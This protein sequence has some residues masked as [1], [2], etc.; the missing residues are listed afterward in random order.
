MT[1]M[2]VIEIDNLVV[3]FPSSQGMLRAVDGVSLKVDEGEV[4]GIQLDLDRREVGIAPSIERRRLGQRD[5]A[6]DQPPDDEDGAHPRPRQDFAFDD[7][8][9]QR[10]GELQ[11][12]Q[13]LALGPRFELGEIDAPAGVGAAD[14]KKAV[15]G[16]DGLE[17]AQQ[18][19]EVSR[20][21]TGPGDHRDA[22]H[23]E[24]L[25]WSSPWASS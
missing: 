6:V 20:P 2:A 17:I 24:P 4:L 11:H 23:D 25:R 19:K 16:S 7:L 15:A 21:G 22:V 18:G 14:S 13:R 12:H 10:R 1:I 8:A 3:E 9:R 5:I